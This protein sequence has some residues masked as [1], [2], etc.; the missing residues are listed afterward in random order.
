MQRT[1]WEEERPYNWRPDYWKETPAEPDTMRALRQLHQLASKGKVTGIGA[2]AI[3]EDRRLYLI[4]TGEAFS[5]P[6][7]AIG[8]IKRLER[9]LHE[10]IDDRNRDNI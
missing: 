1:L 10:M 3:G 8:G 2:V 6:I 5:E 4:A 7:T 9:L